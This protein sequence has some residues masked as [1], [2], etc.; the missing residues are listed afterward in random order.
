[1]ALGLQSDLARKRSITVSRKSG[2]K[3]L[4]A[5]FLYADL[6]FYIDGQPLFGPRVRTHLSIFRLVSLRPALASEGERREGLD[7]SETIR[8]FATLYYK[9]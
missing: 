6:L 9:E 5:P 3:F 1:M 4:P 8:R 7:R 2:F